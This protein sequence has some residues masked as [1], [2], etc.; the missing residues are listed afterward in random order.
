M[1]GIENGV[2]I[3]DKHSFKDFGLIMTNKV[4]SGP[5]PKTKKVAVPARNGSVDMTEVLTND[6]RYN[7]RTINISF[8]AGD[9]LDALPDIISQ[10]QIAW[11]GEKTKI[12]FDDDMAFY[13]LGRI[14]SIEPV[15]NGRIITINITATVDPYKYSIQST[16]DDWLWDPFD[17]DIGIIQE[18]YDLK[19]N[20]TLSVD[21]IGVYKYDNPIIISDSNMAVTHNGVTANIHPGSQVLYD[22]VLSEG[23]NTLTFTGN[24]TVSINYVGGSL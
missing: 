20:G 11:A 18:L 3:C 15:T 9:K 2:T 6:V 23:T 1:L 17:F 7:D 16:A 22:I 4:I 13:W 5:T 14:E 12:A 21:I 24:G 10:I 8:F 19:V